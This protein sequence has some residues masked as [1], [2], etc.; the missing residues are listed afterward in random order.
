MSP[1]RSFLRGSS[2]LPRALALLSAIALAPL[3]SANPGDRDPG[4]GTQGVLFVGGIDP[5]Q[6]GFLGNDEARALAPLADGSALAAGSFDNG[7][8]TD[9]DLSII[10]LTPA[11]ALDPNFGIG[12]RAQV[13]L[14]GD[15]DAAYAML[16][17]D[18]RIV[19]AGTLEIAANTDFGI[20]RFTLDGELDPTFG[21]PVPNAKGVGGRLGYTRIN[22][23]VN[24]ASNDIARAIARQSDGRLIVAGEGIADNQPYSAGCCYRH[25]GLV[26][27]ETD[28]SIDTSFG[29]NGG[30]TAT[31]GLVITPAS[32]ADRSEYVTGIATRPD[33][34][35]P[36]D[37]ITVVGYVSNP[38]IAMVRRY[39]ANGTLDLSFDG[40]GTLLIEDTRENN[41][42]TGLSRIDAALYQPD[43]KLVVAG[44]ARDRGF[45][46]MRFHAD[47]S[48]DASFGS[49]GRRTV[50]FSASTDFDEVAALALQ[51]NGK[52]VAAGYFTVG[53]DANFAVVRLLADGT[54]DPR[55]GDGAG[56]ATHALVVGE[57]DDAAAVTLMPSGAILA[58]GLAERP[59]PTGGLHSDMAFLRLLGDADIFADGFED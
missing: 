41:I 47:G 24:G 59:T 2:P 49:G 6:P 27:L 38:P 48:R 53:E 46:F 4:F 9:G 11:G 28:G 18:D 31:N 36:G 30:P 17:A 54:P 37:K 16:V 40:D 25:F 5:G 13:Q 39:N 34:S 10:R 7:G 14:P 44:L 1:F 8:G 51:P 33:G 29:G 15:Q 56:R 58:A 21:D 19:A 57:L 42:A 20:A 52:I 32:G 43:G 23:G 55:F 45:T 35:L 50:K 12:G 3:A 22:V 26:R